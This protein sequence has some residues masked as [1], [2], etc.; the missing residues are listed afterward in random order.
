VNAKNRESKLKTFEQS[1]VQC[2]GEGLHTQKQPQGMTPERPMAPPMIIGFATVAYIPVAEEWCRT[3]QALSYHPTIIAT[4]NQTWDH[5]EKTKTSCAVV[6]GCDWNSADGHLKK[7]WS[8]RLRTLLDFVEQGRSVFLTDVDAIWRRYEDLGQFSAYDIYLG[9]GTTFPAEV[10][11]RQGWVACGCIGLWRATSYTR[12]VLKELVAQ[13][14]ASCDDQRIL[15]HF[16]L[17]Q[18]IS[19]SSSDPRAFKHSDHVAI[20]D[21]RLVSRGKNIS[22]HAWI[23]AP[24]NAK[25]RESKLK[26]FEQ[27]HVQCGG[28]GLSQ[29]NKDTHIDGFTK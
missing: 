21:K 28:E 2:G 9:Q 6:R 23:D 22:C 26:T 19:W 24:V 25:N 7:L 15:N 8:C 3:M 11:R 29:I 4:D 1:R 12:K 10:Y 5:F 20:W 17:G 16:F 18:N 13:C 27:S 14:G